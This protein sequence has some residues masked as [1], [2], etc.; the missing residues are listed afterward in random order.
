MDWFTDGFGYP[1]TYHQT[2]ESLREAFSA[3]GSPS[4][5]LVVR[6]LTVDQLPLVPFDRYPKEFWS[7]LGSRAGF[8]LMLK[9]RA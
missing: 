1:R 2:P 7:W 9:A 4:T 8:Y 3:P 6:N 5:S